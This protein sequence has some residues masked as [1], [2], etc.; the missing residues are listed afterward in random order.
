MT[1]IDAVATVLW[2]KNCVNTI[3]QI[4]G[5]IYDISFEISITLFQRLYP[6]DAWPHAASG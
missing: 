1:L 3:N 6:R 4:L 2:G 5:K